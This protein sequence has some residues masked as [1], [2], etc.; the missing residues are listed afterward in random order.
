MT[1]AIAPLA[2]RPAW[3]ALEAHHSKIRDLHLRQL[4]S[5][6]PGRGERL[7]VEAAGL[8]FDY[9]KNR[10]TDKTLRLLVQLAKESGLPSA[11]R[12]CS[13]ARRST[14]PRTGRPRIA[15]RA[16]KGKSIVVD[17]PDVVPCS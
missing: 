15:L 13:A 2:S 1:T 3:R 16:P 5:D 12:P 4:F 6:D 7:T 10:I 14:S 9:S 8:F 11:W 17:G